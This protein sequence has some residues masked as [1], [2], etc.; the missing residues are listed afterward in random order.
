M[1]R[2]RKLDHRFVED[3]PETLEP[4]VLYVS[5]R[6]ATAIHLCCCGCE[7]EVVT[8]FSPAQWKMTFDGEGVSLHPSI[9]SWALPCRS[10]YVIRNGQVIVAP[11]WSDEEVEYGRLKDK[12][13][14]SAYYVSKG[15]LGEVG[16]ERAPPEQRDASGHR[17]G[18]RSRWINS[19]SAIW[20]G[21]P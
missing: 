16:K 14:R 12:S 21:K 9:G 10:H 18:R 2:H 20:K 8:P 17:S 15:G 6:Y 4:G 7:R 3:I 19:L 13:A 1:I 11:Q 5:M